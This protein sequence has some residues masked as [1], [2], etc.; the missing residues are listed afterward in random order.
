MSS[1]PPSTS[2]VNP[3]ATRMGTRGRGSSMRR[4]PTRKVGT[5]STS[6]FSTK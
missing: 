5:D 6:R 2:M 3:H 1:S 4:L